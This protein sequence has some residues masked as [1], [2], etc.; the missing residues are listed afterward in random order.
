MNHFKYFQIQIPEDYSSITG[1]ALE[2]RS[3]LWNIAILKQA[4]GR[5][6][7]HAFGSKHPTRNGKLYFHTSKKNYLEC[8]KA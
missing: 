5:S 1:M 7:Q 4:L 8:D 2:N 3:D 6:L